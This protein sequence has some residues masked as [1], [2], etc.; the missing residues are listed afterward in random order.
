VRRAAPHRSGDAWLCAVDDEG[1]GNISRYDVRRR[2]RRCR[3]ATSAVNPE[4]ARRAAGCVG[5]F[6]RSWALAGAVSERVGGCAPPPARPGCR[7]AAPAGV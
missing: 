4:L 6:D 2:G 1:S 3:T 7:Q 5:L